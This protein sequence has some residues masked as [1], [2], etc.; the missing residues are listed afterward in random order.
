V[1]SSVDF[2]ITGAHVYQMFEA[3]CGEVFVA[4]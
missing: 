2:S 4:A 1:P 3:V